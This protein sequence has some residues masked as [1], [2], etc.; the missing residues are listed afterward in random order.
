MNSYTRQA[1]A[2]AAIG[3]FLLTIWTF[4]L[5]A[6]REIGIALGV[7]SAMIVWLL[8]ILSASARFS[9]TKESNEI[10]RRIPPRQQTVTEL[11]AVC[12]YDVRASEHRCPECGT[13]LDRGDTQLPHTPA[14]R[15]LIQHAVLESRQMGHDYV[16]SEHI[17]L[18]II[19]NHDSSAAQILA[20]LGIKES[21][22]REAMLEM[23]GSHQASAAAQA[24]PADA[25][26]PVD[27]K[28]PA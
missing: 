19:A 1:L 27:H 16:G 15:R 13:E 10:V 6:D 9:A 24:L 17:L 23:L 28:T 7:A 26:V 20:E 3:V 4:V 14:L 25:A 11:C 21:Q 12:G 8:L 2:V 5:S 18:A 22:L